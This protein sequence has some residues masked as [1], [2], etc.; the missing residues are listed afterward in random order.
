[1]SIP[2]SC[3]LGLLGLALVGCQTSNNDW[4]KAKSSDPV[5]PS[6]P[7]TAE[8]LESAVVEI[9]DRSPYAKERTIDVTNGVAHELGM[10]TLGAVPANVEF[11]TTVPTAEVGHAS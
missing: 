11:L 6:P 9:N 8:I 4:A 1:M 10:I 2:I 7:A 5:P 3:L